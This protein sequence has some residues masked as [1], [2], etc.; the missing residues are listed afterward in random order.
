MRTLFIML[1][2]PALAGCAGMVPGLEAAAALTV[3]AKDVVGL[4]TA[5]I[6][7]RAVRDVSGTTGIKCGTCQ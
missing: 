2:L 1:A 6:Q 5:I 4:D 7:N 3:L